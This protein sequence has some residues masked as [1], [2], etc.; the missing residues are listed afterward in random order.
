[1]QIITKYLDILGV[2]ASFLCAIHCVLLPLFLSLGLAGAFPWLQSHSLEL[3][4]IFSTLVLASWSLLGSWHK[5]RQIKP[6]IIAT[7]GFLIIFGV[8]SLEGDIAH[9][10]SALGGI[11]IAYAHYVNWRLL[12]PHPVFRR[13]RNIIKLK[14]KAA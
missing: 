2:S 9:Y 13:T 12:H 14:G 10:F 8:H 5:H 3:A 11:L 1:M 4:L 6:I 7:V